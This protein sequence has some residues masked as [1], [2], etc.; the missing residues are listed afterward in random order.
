MRFCKFESCLASFPIYLSW[1]RVITARI[2][3]DESRWFE[4]SYRN[5]ILII[6]SVIKGNAMPPRNILGTYAELEKYILR[7][8]FVYFFLYWSDSIWTRK[9]LPSKWM[10]CSIII[11][12]THETFR[13]NN[14]RSCGE[15]STSMHTVAGM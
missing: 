12:L 4:S 1:Q 14:R 2:T 6:N 3:L 13:Y 10:L 15:E 7:I 9:K 11:W 5:C 8:R